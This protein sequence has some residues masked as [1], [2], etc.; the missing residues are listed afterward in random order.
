[1]NNIEQTLAERETS[2]GDYRDHAHTAQSIKNVMLSSTKWQSLS[3]PQKESLD[4]IAHKVGRILNGDPNFIDSWRDLAGY[5]M[6]IVNILQTTEGATDNKI[7][8]VKVKG[9]KLVEL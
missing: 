1:M 9:D 2:H 7:V 8:K 6:L 4:M 5:A 3:D